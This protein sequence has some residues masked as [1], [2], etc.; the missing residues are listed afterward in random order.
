MISKSELRRVGYPTIKDTVEDLLRRIEDIVIDAYNSGQ[1][2]VAVAFP[3]F[4]NANVRQAVKEKLRNV[5]YYVGE[6]SYITY[7]N[8][9]DKLVINWVE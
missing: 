1:G 6:Y 9:V 7:G 8:R 5:G 3:E 4:K 2:D